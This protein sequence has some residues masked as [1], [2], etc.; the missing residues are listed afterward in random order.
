MSAYALPWSVIET[1]GSRSSKA[2]DPEVHCRVRGERGND[3]VSQ[4]GSQ[5]PAAAQAT[6]RWKVCEL[7]TLEITMMVEE[8]I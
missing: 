6:W 4:A 8:E 2:L 3:N 7:P 5:A 1:A